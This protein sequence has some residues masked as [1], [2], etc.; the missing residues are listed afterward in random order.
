MF[1]LRAGCRMISGGT[2]PLPRSDTRASVRPE[3]RPR[4]A[5]PPPSEGS[6]LEEGGAEVA[7][8]GAA[9]PD[10]SSGDNGSAAA[11][12]RAGFL[13]EA[14]QVEK[15]PV[16]EP[17]LGFHGGGGT[18]GCQSRRGRHSLQRPLCSTMWIVS[19]SFCFAIHCAAAKP[20]LL[21]HRFSLAGDQ[22]KSQTRIKA[23]CLLT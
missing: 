16:R 20:V 15:K 6:D 4:L 18:K 5:P 2:P 12:R 23:A 11:G 10:G 17:R 9:C 21:K 14:C 1:Y 19:H 8:K 7:D 13:S 3:G 22:H